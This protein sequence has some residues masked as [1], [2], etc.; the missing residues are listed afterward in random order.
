MIVVPRGTVLSPE[1][2]EESQQG[3]RR[4]PSSPQSLTAFTFRSDVGACHICLDYSRL[5]WNLI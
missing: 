4:N 5:I 2:E 1:M 3:T